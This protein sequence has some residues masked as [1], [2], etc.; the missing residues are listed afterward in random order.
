MFAKSFNASAPKLKDIVRVSKGLGP[1]PIAGVTIIPSELIRAISYKSSRQYKFKKR[2]LTDEDDKYVDSRFDK[3][4]V[5]EIT[6]LQNDSLSI[7]MD[8]YRPAA[9]VLKK[10]TSYDVMIYIKKSLQSF[11]SG[12]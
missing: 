6:K 8:K 9:G 4:L 12:H 7:F 11:R 3:D 1:L 2:L 5:S 10:M